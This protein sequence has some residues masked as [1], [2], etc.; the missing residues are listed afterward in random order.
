MAEG[1]FFGIGL[2]F[3]LLFMAGLLIAGTFIAVMY[4]CDRGNRKR[5]RRA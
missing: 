4:A 3:A 5:A 2:A 1:F